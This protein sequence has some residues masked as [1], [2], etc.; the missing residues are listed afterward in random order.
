MSKASDARAALPSVII[1]LPPDTETDLK[2]PTLPP[3]GTATPKIMGRDFEQDEDGGWWLLLGIID[4]HLKPHADG[5]WEWIIG[6]SAY[7]GTGLEDCLDSL[8]RELRFLRRELGLDT[9]Q[10]TGIDA[11]AFH[12]GR[13]AATGLILHHETQWL[14]EYDRRRIHE[15]KPT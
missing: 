8:S 2:P 6:S 10:Q 13:Q 14:E 1:N 12:L 15:R 9:H 3:T 5:G 7:K 11:Y 4:I